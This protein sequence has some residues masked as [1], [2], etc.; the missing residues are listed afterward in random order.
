MQNNI[1]AVLD[2]REETGEPMFPHI[3]HPNFGWAVTAEDLKKLEGERFFEV[4]NGHPL[5]HNHGDSLHS[6]TEQ[7]WDEVI[8]HYLHEGK[9]AMY[10][11]AVD[12]AHNYHQFDSTRAN[13]GRG[14]IYV[15]SQELTPDS[16]IAAMERGDFYASTG[17]RLHEINFDGRTLSIEIQAEEGV[18]YTIQF[19]G[20]HADSL[21]NPGVLLKTVEGNEAAYTFSGNELYVRAKIVSDKMKENPYAKGETEVAWTQPVIQN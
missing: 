19:I 4:Y 14:W 18:D 5:V 15:K 12:D 10:G 3:N 13:P 7:M 17:V 2:Q 8:T 6:G 11:I 1:D 9:P 21:Q 16:L 20:T